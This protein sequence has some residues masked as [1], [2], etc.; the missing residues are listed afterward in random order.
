M[1]AHEFVRTRGARARLAIAGLAAVAAAFPLEFSAFA[2]DA[3]VRVATAEPSSVSPQ[4]RAVPAARS[5]ATQAGGALAPI[6]S[7]EVRLAALDP[8]RPIEYLELAE[9][10]ADGLAADATGTTAPQPGA[11]A[12]RA[13]ARQLYGL[14][15]ALDPARLGRSAMLGIATLA[16]TAEARRRAELAAELVGGR[17]ASRESLRI[18]PAALESLSRAFSYYRRGNG[19]KA[20]AALRQS[21]ADAL[22][23]AIGP[24]IAG[25]AEAFRSECRAMRGANR[26]P[27]DPE[28]ESRLLFVELALRR[29]EIRG[30]GL[31]ILLQGDAPLPEIDL[32]DPQ[33]LWGVNPKRAFWREGGWK[34]PR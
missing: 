1:S 6:A 11:E 34:E 21:G 14:A 9:E 19:T 3:T 13:L 22:L 16:E 2:G 23:D 18:D 31:D 20:L 28:T 27:A 7:W 33:A 26:L 32:A 15:G 12:T 29:G 4:E 30:V 5:S 8:A 10:V 24:G 25:G 17:G